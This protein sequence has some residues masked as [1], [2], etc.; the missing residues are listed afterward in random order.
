MEGLWL[1]VLVLPPLLGGACLLLGLV[2]LVGSLQNR[3]VRSHEWP[4][5]PGVVLAAEVREDVSQDGIAASVSWS[6]R[7]RYEYAVAGVGY[8]SDQISLAAAPTTEKLAQAT[9]ARYPPGCA[10]TVRYCPERPGWAVLEAQPV[11]VRY[12]LLVVAGALFAIW[13]VA[14]AAL[15]A[16]L[17][18]S[19]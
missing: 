8:T 10:V 1:A 11:P 16:S 9:V 19:R 15:T 17:H 14:L 4:R 3:S 7:I 5:V 13:L 2:E 12:G 6:P 18:V